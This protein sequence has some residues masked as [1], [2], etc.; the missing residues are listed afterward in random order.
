MGDKHWGPIR[1]VSVYERDAKEPWY[2]LTN[3]MDESPKKIVERYKRRMWIEAMFRDLKNRDWG[4]GMD[5]AKLTKSGR[6]DRH[7]LVLALIYIFLAAFGAAAEAAGIGEQ[8]KANTVEKRVLS[9]H[10]SETTFY[11]PPI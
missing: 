2:L 11:K 5:K 9:S 8:L 4:L 6:L 1:L 7:F 3:L 10:A